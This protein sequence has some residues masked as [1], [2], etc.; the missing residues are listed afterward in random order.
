MVN[1]D[2]A[3]KLVHKTAVQPSHYNDQFSYLMSSSDQWTDEIDGGNS[4]NITKMDNLPPSKGN[5]YDYSHK[6]LYTTIYKNF[7]GGYKYK[8]GINFY[9]LTANVDYTLCLEIIN[10]DYQLWHKSQI[11]VDKGT[12]TGLSIGNVSIRKLSHRYTQSNGQQQFMYYHRV[13]VNFRKLATGNRFFL[14]FLV[15][16][17]QTGTDLATY[18]SQFSGVYIIT[19]GI[20]GKVSNIDPDKVYDYHTAFDIKPTQVVYNVDINANNKKILNVN[21]D[22]NN[23]N[24]A[25][26]VG[27]VKEIKPHT[28]NDLYRNYFEEVYDFTNATNYKLSKTSSGI[29]F[30]YLSSSSGNTLRD[31]GIPLRTIDDIKKEG[32]NLNDYNISFSPPDFITKYTLCL[33]FYHWRNRN[34]SL[35]KKD[36][37][38]NTTLLDLYYTTSGNT[39]NLVVNNQR[40]QLTLP[41]DFN[42]KKIVIWL[43]EDFSQNITKVKISNYSAILSLQAVRYTNEQNFEFTTQDGILSKIMFSPNFYDTSSEQYHKVML[44]EKLN[45]SYVL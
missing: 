1:K 44:Q 7:Q 35:K 31:M 21:L 2:Y 17:P 8:M 16:I 23:D 18:P 19:Y 32:L 27:M 11:S 38:S 42:G 20:V 45:G 5:F 6:V 9:R 43:A 34:F 29:V 36:T 39:V 25:A 40:R 26:T 33:I 22:R 15:D 3:D 4:F 13:I 28:I 30:R 14:H 37:N 10:T 24:S 41:S 12:S